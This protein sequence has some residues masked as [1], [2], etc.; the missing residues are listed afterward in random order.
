MSK[1]HDAGA[2]VREDCQYIR[3]AVG[4]VILVQSDAG[5]AALH[6]LGWDDF[7]LKRQVHPLVSPILLRMTW[8]DALEVNAEAQPP[9]RQSA[10]P[11]ERRRG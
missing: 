9:D 2:F 4:E 6:F 11:I 7:A 3:A 1:I 8:R 5:F 10:Q